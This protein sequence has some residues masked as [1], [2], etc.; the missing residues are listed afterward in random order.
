MATPIPAKGATRTEAGNVGQLLL[1]RLEHAG[2]PL[3]PD[4]LFSQEASSVPY[5]AL[6]VAILTL[7]Q[8]GLVELTPDWRVRLAPQR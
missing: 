6:R 8:D 5:L 4:E 3:R 2:R 7:L 1:Q